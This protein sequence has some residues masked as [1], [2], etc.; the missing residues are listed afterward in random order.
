[1]PIF[2]GHKENSIN[3]IYEV[4]PRYIPKYIQGTKDKT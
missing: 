3:I 1:M 4:S 2:K